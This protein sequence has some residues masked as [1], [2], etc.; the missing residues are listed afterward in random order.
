[1]QVRAVA[2]PAP[3]HNGR[4]FE[5]RRMAKGQPSAYLRAD[6]GVHG[7]YASGSAVTLCYASGFEEKPIGPCH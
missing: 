6:R 3:G 4:Q 2:V 5:E 1:M 7:F